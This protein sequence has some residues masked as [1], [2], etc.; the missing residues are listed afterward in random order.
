MLSTARQL[1]PTIPM[2]NEVHGAKLGRGYA[3]MIWGRDVEKWGLKASVE[4]LL[5]N[6]VWFQ[7]SWPTSQQ[8][9]DDFRPKDLA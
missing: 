5:V 7:A 4:L 8:V 9:H 1:F 3:P 2:G 6:Q